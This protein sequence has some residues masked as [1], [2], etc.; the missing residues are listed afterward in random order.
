VKKDYLPVS[1]DDS[2]IDESVF[3][4]KYWTQIWQGRN[5]E[6]VAKQ[7]IERRDEFKV[8]S[9]YLSKLPQK[10]RIFDGG[11]GTGEWAVYFALKGLDVSGLDI[12]RKTV[13]RLKEKF[14]EYEKRFIFGD[15]R[16][17]GFSDN[18]FDAYYSW[19]VFEHFEEGLAR[20]L[21]EAWRILKP[22]GYLFISVPFQNYWHLLRNQRKLWIADKAFDK[23]KGYT[24]KMR[25]YQWRFTKPEL[26]RELEINGFKTLEIRPINKWHGVSR[27]IKVNLHIEFS[28]KIHKTVK[29]LLYPFISHSCIAHMLLGVGVKRNGNDGG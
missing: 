22:G 3:V 27:L 7:A 11:C 20:C 6:I 21:S 19:G 14:P 1:F 8:I 10:S 28:S 13:E 26:Q 25:F 18:Y 29:S 4:E 12:S 9:K 15:I 17:T 16:N 23:K 2:S 5:L 24:S